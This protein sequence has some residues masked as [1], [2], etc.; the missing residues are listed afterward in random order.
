MQSVRLTIDDCSL[1]SP[2]VRNRRNSLRTSYKEDLSI[3]SLLIIA[4]TPFAGRN[5]RRKLLSIRVN[6]ILGEDESSSRG[7]TNHTFLPGNRMGRPH[8]SLYSPGLHSPELHCAKMPSLCYNNL[9][10]AVYDHVHPKIFAITKNRLTGH[11]GRHY[12]AF[13]IKNDGLK[14]NR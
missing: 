10:I 4:Q 2:T 8:R 12:D 13:Y 5:H 1:S 9:S 7:R 11:I 14:P 3:F 6:K